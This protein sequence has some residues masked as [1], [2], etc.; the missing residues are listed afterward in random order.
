LV[1]KVGEQVWRKTIVQV[2]V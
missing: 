2:M 1:F